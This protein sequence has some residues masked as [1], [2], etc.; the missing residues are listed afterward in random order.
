MLMPEITSTDGFYSNVRFQMKRFDS[1]GTAYLTGDFNCW[2]EGSIAFT[3]RKLLSA[4][5][6]LPP[7][8]YAY[9]I[10]INQYHK[11]QE[12]GRPARKRSHLELKLEK[13]YHNPALSQF[14]CLSEGLMELRIAVPRETKKVELH[15]KGKI[16]FKNRTKVENYDIVSFLVDGSSPY[17]F[18][19]EGERLPHSGNYYPKNS[20]KR[21]Y[22]SSGIIY[23]IFPDRFN[24]G[25]GANGEGFEEWGAKPLWNNYFGGTIRGIVEKLDYLK[26]LGVEYIYI[27]PINEAN[28]NH[29]YD[30]SNY[31][32]IDPILGNTDSLKH[33][34]S[35]SHKRGMKVILDMVFNHSSTT[36]EPFLDLIRNGRNSEF[37]NWYIFHSD[38][39]KV[40]RGRYRP[41][42]K[43][44]EPPYETFMGHGML[45]K[46]NHSNKE[47]RN[48]FREVIRYYG[49]EL[50][51]DGFRFDVAHS[52]HL[53]FFREIGNDLKRTNKLIL[54][55]AWC[56]SP[57]FLKE[58]YWNSVTNYYMRDAVIS[59][60]KGS[61]T[62]SELYS[63][64]EKFL[65]TTGRTEAERVMNISDS[66]DTVRILNKLGGSKRKV[67]LAFAILYLLT[68]LPT[69]YYG[70]EVGLEG[71]RDPDDRRCFP[72]KK[73]DEE[74]LSFFK[75]L[76]DF[77]IKNDI[78]YGGAISFT[79]RP[80]V[81]TLIRF[82]K[83]CQ[84]RL[85]VPKGRT[86]LP[87]KFSDFLVVKHSKAASGLLDRGDFCFVVSP[88][89]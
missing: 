53:D 68:G 4:E 75:K 76:G 82:K 48:Y 40:Y 89:E 70:D 85:C 86:K 12:N 63:R 47:V 44:E 42:S 19:V 55:E 37:Y 77:R 35:E 3:G 34:V 30:V 71:G 1:V 11:H 15:Y 62:I 17:S 74:L 21:M 25:K 84:I 64:L 26:N 9:S 73:K 50:N 67:E 45:P 13:A 88:N 27:N 52:I 29:R 23:H 46:L 22:D 14:S 65:I 32:E 83:K 54:G 59:Y 49:D 28:S 80:N 60:V 18:T 78:A 72:W 81:D 41:D 33:L 39:F 57:I 51:V 16:L 7:G 69:I 24:R 56:V 43:G 20:T 8:R 5:I 38:N 6:A 66:H 36:F 79:S 10:L 87:T 58:K 31:Y 2:G 61:I